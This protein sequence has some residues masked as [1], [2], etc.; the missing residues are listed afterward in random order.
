MLFQQDNA[1]PHMAAVTQHALCDVQQLSWPARSPDDLPIQ[2]IWDIMMWELSLS[3]EPA[4]TIAEL[5]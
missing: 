2:H 3:Q 5:R 4:T 1:S